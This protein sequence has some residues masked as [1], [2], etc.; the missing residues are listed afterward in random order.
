MLDKVPNKHPAR[1]L[2]WTLLTLLLI[3]VTLGF[4]G[5]FGFVFFFS[6]F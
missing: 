1:S 6:S 2:V 4:G 3:P 5:F